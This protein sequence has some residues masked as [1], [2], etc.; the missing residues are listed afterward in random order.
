[1]GDP[2]VGLTDVLVFIVPLI[3]LIGLFF[4]ASRRLLALKA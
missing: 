3:A 2:H 1:M 4:Y